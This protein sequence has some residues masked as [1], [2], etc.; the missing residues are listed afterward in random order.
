MTMEGDGVL[1]AEAYPERIAKARG[2]PGEFLLASGR[3]AFVDPAD[4]LA[5]EPWLAVAELGGGAAR[6]RILLA[7]PLEEDALRREFE[8]RITIKDAVEADAGGR[9]RATRRLILGALVIEERALDRPSDE[10]IAA[11]LT[12]QVRR[13]GLARLR[14]NEAALSLRARVGFLRGLEPGAWP[15]LSDEAL[16]AGAGDWLTPLLPGKSSLAEVEPLGLTEAL[17][18]LVGRDL[19]RRLER[20]APERLA[21]PA[22]PSHVIDYAAEGGPRAE[23]RV[24]ELYGLDRHPT[25][26][27]GRVALTLALLSPAHRPIQVTRDLPGF[28]RGSWKAVRTDMKGRYPKHL[29]PED[30]I[31]AN[32]TTRAKCRP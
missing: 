29:W 13:D 2:K 30:P 28:W 12:E 5:R 23:V 32:A 21:T 8:G 17:R 25:V 20:E 1:L 16:A 7:A 4:P 10:L 15:D 9:L 26:A 19:L 22:G 24:Q 31:G 14:W 27:G 11:H 3:G 6:D 18:A